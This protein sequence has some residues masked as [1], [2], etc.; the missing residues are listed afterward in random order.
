MD[1]AHFAMGM[2]PL[3]SGVR[4]YEDPAERSRAHPFHVA[5]PPIRP[6]LYFCDREGNPIA[7]ESLVDVTGDLEVQED[8]GLTVRTEMEP[9]GELTDFD[10]RSRA[11]GEW[12]GEGGLGRSIGGML[13]FD[14]P[15]SARPWWGQPTHRRRHLPGASP[16]GRNQH[17]SCDPQ[18]GIESGL[19]RCELL[20]EGVLL[21]AVS[22]PL[23]ANGQTSWLIDAP[24]PRRR[25]VRLRGV[26]ALRCSR[27]GSV[28]RRGPGNGPGTR[29]FTTLSVCRWKRRMSQE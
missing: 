12:I 14:L 26:G 16:G 27:G 15:T 25:Y 19:V 7:A 28:Q 11:A 1:F 6:V 13:R 5:I 3:R 9:L 23:E 29:T 18:P 2:A 20:R 21:D 24:I 17:G 22:I 8:G 10:P 4:E